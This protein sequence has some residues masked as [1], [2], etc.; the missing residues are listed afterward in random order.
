MGPG[1]AKTEREE[2]EGGDGWDE[3]G[4]VG[5]VGK[6]KKGIC[7]LFSSS[8]ALHA[9]LTTV[10]DKHTLQLCIMTGYIR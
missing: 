8:S 5:I 7:A 3:R 6:E 4:D 9:R 2:Q 10:I 1:R